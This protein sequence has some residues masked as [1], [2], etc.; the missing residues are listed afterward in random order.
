MASVMVKVAGEG[1]VNKAHR[2]SDAGPTSGSS[3]IYEVVNVPGGVSEE[4]VVDLIKKTVKSV[5]HND[6]YEVDYAAIAG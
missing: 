3:V 5:P 2:N 1:L 4:V 6:S